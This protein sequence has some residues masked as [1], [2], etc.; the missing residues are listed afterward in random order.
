LQRQAQIALFK[1]PHRTDC[2]RVV[3][4]V[5]VLIA[6]TEILVPRVVVVVLRRTPVSGTGKTT[7]N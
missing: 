1:I 5:V 7:N 2:I 6:A 4:I 3:L